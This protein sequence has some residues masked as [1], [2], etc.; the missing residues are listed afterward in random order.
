M[1]LTIA[2]HTFREVIRKK[3]LHVLIGLGILIIAVSPFIPTTDEP[4]ARIK[5][6]LVVF[7]QVVVLLCIVG[8]IFLSAASLPHEIEDRTIYGILSKPVSRLKIVAGKIT[9]FALLSAL[10]L[11]ILG[12]LNVVTIQR[13]A[14]KLPEGYRGILKARN[15]FAASQFS[16]KG[17]SHHVREGI[18]WIEG[19]R[20][21][22][23]LWSFSDLCK[24]PDDK[25]SFEV[26]FGLKIDSG[27]KDVG[28]IPLVVGIEDTGTGQCKTSVLSAKIDEPLTVK[29]DPELVRKSSILNITA[30][31]IDSMDYIGVTGE[32]AK[33]YTVRKGFIS[34]Y[35]KAIGITFLKFLLIVTIAVMG[36]TYLSAPVSIVSALVV[37]LCGH[38][39]D[40]VKDFSLL[41]QSY[42][43]HEHALPTALKKPNILLV[44]IDY[45][46]KK[47]LEWLTV[48][49]PDFKRFD[50]L[51]FLLKGINISWETVGVSVGYTAL[52]AG[53]CLFISS[54]IFKKREFF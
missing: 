48:I 22:I 39:L 2:G 1:I 18:A 14:S 45:L 9:G 24:K 44:Y 49:L 52:Y 40:F 10:L 47:P 20:S 8:I 35:T 15:E 30:F 29:I 27:R 53:I 6:M 23:A 7:F 25:S 33:L 12:L 46:I 32:D 42:D 16:I 3:I 31:P 50:S 51:K 4:D 17:K 21:G 37:F 41:I 11:I 19:G 38:I 28:A 13:I 26:E 5:M 43:V 34:N 36:S 54:I